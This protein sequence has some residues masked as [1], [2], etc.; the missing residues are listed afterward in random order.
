MYQL[1]FSFQSFWLTKTNNYPG[2]VKWRAPTGTSFAIERVDELLESV[3]TYTELKQLAICIDAL[4]LMLSPS[5]LGRFESKVGEVL[6]N[7]DRTS[8]LDQKDFNSIVK[9]S[10]LLDLVK[11]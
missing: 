10:T 3:S 11:E 6:D 4:F 1:C 5:I 9:V 8:S 7:R 2:A